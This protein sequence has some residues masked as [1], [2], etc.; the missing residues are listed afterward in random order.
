[1]FENLFLLFENLF[2]LLGSVLLGTIPDLVHLR[3]SCSDAILPHASAQTRML[4]TVG[5]RID[6]QDQR[7]FRLWLRDFI[8]FWSICSFRILRLLRILW[9]LSWQS[10]GSSWPLRSRS[11]SRSSSFCMGWLCSMLRFRFRCR[12]RFRHRLT[13]LFDQA[14]EDCLEIG[15]R[16]SF[17]QHG[18]SGVKLLILVHSHRS[19]WAKP[20]QLQIQGTRSQVK[21]FCVPW[22]YKVFKIF[23]SI[24]MTRNSET[25]S[26]DLAGRSNVEAW[27]ERS[28][29][30]KTRVSQD[31]GETLWHVIPN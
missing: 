26:G 14:T 29:W 16:S 1:M 31:L 17:L 4:T 28:C 2:L 18:Q 10:L 8:R 25:S 22:K 19:R 30:P 12:L 24:N 13:K 27:A 9:N 5:G 3:A 7:F 11:R 21:Y 20:N 15:I 6:L 23:T